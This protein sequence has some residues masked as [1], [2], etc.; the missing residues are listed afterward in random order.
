MEIVYKSN[1]VKK[2]CTELRRAKRDFPEKIAKK[3]LSKVNFLEAAEN[4]ESVINNQIL[5]FHDLKGSLDGAYAIDIDGRKSPYRLIVRF[6]DY[7]KELVFADSKSIEIIKI[8]EVSK[9]Y[10]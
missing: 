10:E 1:T 5:H 9:H 4:L 3:L 2:Q 8:T 7:S 6:D